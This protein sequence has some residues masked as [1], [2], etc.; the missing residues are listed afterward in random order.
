M[1]Y[2]TF[3]SVEELSSH[4]QDPDWVIVDCRFSLA[5]PGKGRREYLTAHLPGA[6]YMH[7]D[8]DLSG[9]VIPGR[10]GR[11]P[12]PAVEAAAQ[13]FSAVGIGN[14]TQVVAYDDAGGALAA[15]RLWWMLRWLGHMAAAVLD[16]G[17]QA[18]CAAGLPVQSGEVVLQPSLFIPAPRPELMASVEEVERIRGDPAFRLVDARTVER[19]HGENETIDP[20]AGHIPGAICAPY[21]ENLGP[22]GRLL[23]V[24]ALRQKYTRLM[25]GAPP[26]KVVFYCGSGVTST[27]NIMAMLHAGLG[28]A[29]LYAG[30]WSEWIANPLRPAAK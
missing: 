17:W 25:A 22:D 4:L 2:T 30:S 18:W 15:G 24:D 1:P 29:R 28:E 3:I 12:L 8:E 27:L 21:M 5:D 20:V 26:Q 19:Y 14:K 13:R 23:S 16:G 10:T 9:P 7:L 6:I 11:H